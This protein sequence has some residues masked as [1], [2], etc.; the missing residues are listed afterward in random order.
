MHEIPVRDRIVRGNVI[1]HEIMDEPGVQRPE[2]FDI[3]HAHA[4]AQ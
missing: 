3:V 1:G 4:L 2:F